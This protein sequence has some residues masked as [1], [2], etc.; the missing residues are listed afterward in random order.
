MHTLHQHS[1]QHTST[2]FCP[3]LFSTH[4]SFAPWYDVRHSVG[5]QWLNGYWENVEYRVARS[6]LCPSIQVNVQQPTVSP[7]LVVFMLGFKAASK[8]NRLF[9]MEG[10]LVTTFA[11]LNLNGWQNCSTFY[12]YWMCTVK[13]FRP[14]TSCCWIVIIWQAV[15]VSACNYYKVLITVDSTDGDVVDSDDADCG[16]LTGDRWQQ[17]RTNKIWLESLTLSGSTTSHCIHTAHKLC[18]LY[19]GKNT[20]KNTIWLFASLQDDNN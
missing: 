7:I 11:W 10:N 1:A 17:L 3:L 18:W 6:H 2:M 13:L 20:I 4:W 19:A 16:S 8:P 14:S 12:M 5:A 15:A 9:Q